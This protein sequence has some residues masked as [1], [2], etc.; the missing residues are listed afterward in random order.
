[1]H[2][3]AGEHLAPCDSVVSLAPNTD[4][5]AA[6]LCAD[7]RLFTTADAAVTWSAPATFA[8]AIALAPATTGYLVVSA[9]RPECAGAQLLTVTDALAS[10]VVGCYAMSTPATALPGTVAVSEAAGAIWLW[11]GD[12]LVR[13]TDAG[14]TFK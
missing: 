13:S 7:G 2:A 3:P 5:A 4:T 10:T 6:V 14:A 9:G 1:V 8:G 12:Q 11:A